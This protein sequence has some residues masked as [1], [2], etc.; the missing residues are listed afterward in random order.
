MLAFGGMERT[1]GRW[2]ELLEGDEGV[3]GGG[4][5]GL[6]IVEF[7]KPKEGASINECLIVCV[8]AGEGE[9]ERERERE[10]GVRERL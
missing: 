10:E 9:R 7:V 1:E 8:L 5:V 2:R 4:G 3:I 6:K